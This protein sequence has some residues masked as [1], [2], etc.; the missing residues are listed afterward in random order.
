M[1]ILSLLN[2]LPLANVAEQNEAL[3][4]IENYQLAGKGIGWTDIHLLASTLLS[5]ALLWTADKK[6]KMSA[7]KLEVL[8]QS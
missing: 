6:L 1:E 8:Y 7:Q 5:Q 3:N 4:F 2:N